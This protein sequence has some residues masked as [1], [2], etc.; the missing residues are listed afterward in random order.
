MRQPGKRGR[1]ACRRRYD[2]RGAVVTAVSLPPGVRLVRDRGERRPLAST[3]GCAS[4]AG[5]NGPQSPPVTLLAVRPRVPVMG[6]RDHR[7]SEPASGGLLA[8]SLGLT[9]AA[10]TRP[11]PRSNAP[12][13]HVEA[14]LHALFFCSS[15]AFFSASIAASRP[16]PCRLPSS[17]GRAPCA[18]RRGPRRSTAAHTDRRRL[19]RR[20][21]R[22]GAGRAGSSPVS[23]LSSACC[24]G[25]RRRRSRAS[26]LPA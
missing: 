13:A 17:A 7:R 15:R 9:G 20:R 21:R 1:P 26:G 24:F 22:P 5:F 3:D 19:C 10:G 23:P 14:S 18:A 8:S 4:R 16:R 12:D 25:R 6:N 2:D 11:R